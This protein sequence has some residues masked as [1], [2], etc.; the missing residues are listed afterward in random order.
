MFS[1]EALVKKV[2]SAK[3]DAVKFEN[4]NKA[5]GTRL[6]LK[7]QELKGLA[8]AVRIAVSEVKNA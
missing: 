3:E 8:Q 1:F 4:G 6:R 2:E 7:M 5:A